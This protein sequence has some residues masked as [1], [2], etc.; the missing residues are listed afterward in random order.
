MSLKRSQLPLDR[1]QS[2]RSTT[3]C[4]RRFSLL[5]SSLSTFANYVTAMLRPRPASHSA[6]WTN[7]LLLFFSFISLAKFS[8]SE[9]SQYVRSQDAA[10][11]TIYLADDRKPALYTQ[12]FGDCLGD[13]VINVTRFD[14]AYYAD[15]MTVIFDLAGSSSIANESVMRTSTTGCLCCG[16][17]LTLFSVYWCICL[18]SFSIRSDIRSLPGPDI[19]VRQA[20]ISN[21]EALLI[22]TVSVP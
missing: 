9:N 19:Q 11:N 18:R 5:Y 16:T 6:P 21:M 3:P 10:G 12:D 14:A 17:L 20:L 7:I 2:I 13:S 4:D 8:S 22:R 15:N 1:D